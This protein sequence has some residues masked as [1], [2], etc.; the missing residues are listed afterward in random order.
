MTLYDD[1]FGTTLIVEKDQ[2]VYQHKN[3]IYNNL[4]EEKMP[5]EILLILEEII[6]KANNWSEFKKLI[7]RV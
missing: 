3:G 4:I 1:D 6:D 5:R 7:G 2:L